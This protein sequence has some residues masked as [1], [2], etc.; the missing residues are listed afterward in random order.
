M[1]ISFCVFLYGGNVHAVCIMRDFLFVVEHIY[2]YLVI[3]FYFYD[4]FYSQFILYIIII[5][6]P[7]VI[8]E[9]I[10]SNRHNITMC[11]LFYSHFEIFHCLHCNKLD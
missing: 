9:L 4:V 8:V 1:Y 6:L 11:S 10:S 5:N 3:H 7:L 2:M